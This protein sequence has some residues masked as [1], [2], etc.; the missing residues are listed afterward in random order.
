MLHFSCICIMLYLS[1]TLYIS[2]KYQE[3]GEYMHFNVKEDII[4]LTPLWKGERFEDGRPKVSDEDIAELKKLTQE[5]IWESLWENDYKN[6]FESHLMRIHEDDRKLIGRAVTAAYIPSRPDLFDV[7]E[8]IGH[9]EGRKG[10]HNLWVVD[11]LVDGDLPAGPECRH[12][13]RAGR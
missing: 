6:Q 11:K 2:F 1:N 4:Q 9:S 13:L 7:V 3:E 10:T 12:P 5:Q 8:E